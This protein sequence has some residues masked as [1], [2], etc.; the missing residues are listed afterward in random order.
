MDPFCSNVHLSAHPH[1]SV[2]CNSFSKDRG[3]RQHSGRAVFISDVVQQY[4][5][6]SHWLYS[7]F[8]YFVLRSILYSSGGISRKRVC[9]LVGRLPLFAYL[10]NL[11]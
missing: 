3:R 8:P 11:N 4:I 10:S 2:S 9:P 1:R 5:Q 6:Y 7:V